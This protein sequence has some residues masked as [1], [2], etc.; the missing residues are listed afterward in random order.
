M[1]STGSRRVTSVSP[2]YE[3][4]INGY[5]QNVA[6]ASGSPDD[7]NSVDTEYSDTTGPIT[8]NST[9]GGSVVDTHPFPTSECSDA[10]LSVCLTD[11]QLQTEIDGVIKNK[12]WSGGTSHLFFLFTPQDVG[13]CADAA[14]TYC[15]FESYCAYHSFFES[16]DGAGTVVYANQPYVGGTAACDSGGDRPNGDD[17]D[18][19]LNDASHEMNE[20]VTDPLLSAWFDDAGGEIGDKCV[21][22]LRGRRAD[23]ERHLQPAGGVEQQDARSRHGRDWHLPAALLADLAPDRKRHGKGGLPSRNQLRRIKSLRHLG[24]RR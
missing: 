19:T 2:K 9:F 20:S 21:G 16:S 23:R 13:S 11:A 22:P 3:S 15:G 8:G 7:V 24:P 5:F 6:A 12:G 17:A 1:P 14:S 18:A 10:G 4:V